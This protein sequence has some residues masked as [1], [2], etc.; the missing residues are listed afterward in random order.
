MTNREHLLKK[1]KTPEAVS[2]HYREMQK[3]SQKTRDGKKA[4]QTLIRI[5]GEDYFKKLGRKGGRS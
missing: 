2:E 3:K 1:F 5:Y 4:A